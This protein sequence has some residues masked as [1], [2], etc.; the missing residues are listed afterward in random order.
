MVANPELHVASSAARYPQAT[1]YLSISQVARESRTQSV[2]RY[3]EFSA[4]K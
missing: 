2:K 1:N 4:T 3:A